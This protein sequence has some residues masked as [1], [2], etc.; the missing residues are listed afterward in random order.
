MIISNG[1]GVPIAELRRTYLPRT[2]HA[3][4]IQQGSNRFITVPLDCVTLL[5]DAL[6]DAHERIEVRP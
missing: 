3:L 1:Q 5:A 4:K 6:I 2:G